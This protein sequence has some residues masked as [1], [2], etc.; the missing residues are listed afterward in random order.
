MY[1]CEV[2]LKTAYAT[3][4]SEGISRNHWKIGGILGKFRGGWPKIEELC[5]PNEKQNSWTG[6]SISPTS[7]RK[8]GNEGIC[9][10]HVREIKGKLKG[11]PFSPQVSIAQYCSCH[12]TW[13]I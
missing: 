5:F 12:G 10:K 3:G 4:E 6:K 2:V 7:G 13:G 1:S 8:G 11:I 9:A